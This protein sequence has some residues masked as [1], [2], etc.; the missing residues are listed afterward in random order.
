MSRAQT[1]TAPISNEDGVPASTRNAALKSSRRL[2]NLDVLRCI[3]A[4][5]VLVMHAIGRGDIQIV[6]LVGCFLCLSGFLIPAS[7]ERSSGYGKFAMK[8]VLRIG[9]AF[10]ASILLVAA[11]FGLKAAGGTFAFYLTMGLLVS[12]SASRDLSLWSLAL[13][14][15]IYAGHAF[16]RRFK[17]L[18]NSKAVF[19]I[20]FVIT[21]GAIF[22]A[23]H[24]KWAFHGP[25]QPTP[26]YILS[27]A[28]MFPLGNLIYLNIGRIDRL[29]WGL[30]CA[31]FAVSFLLWI[32][33]LSL[34]IFLYLP[35]GAIAGACAVIIAYKAPQVEFKFPDLSY[36]IYVYHE[37][38]LFWL[39]SLKRALTVSTTLFLLMAITLGM[40]TLS[41]Y[42]IEGPA[43]RLKKRFSKRAGAPLARPEVG[44]V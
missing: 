17:R 5:N 39:R 32:D 33:R 23:Y 37:P 9:P 29:K 1:A 15:I 34:S 41:W 25:L 6:P 40:A 13:E 10:A 21:G 30:L 12:R 24:P 42:L 28:A 31:V 38:I 43:L 18:W 16:F 4:T 26:T 14:E 44:K 35:G 36:G 20:Y 7:L 8:R 22:F 27:I 2:P 3:L 19:A 11:L